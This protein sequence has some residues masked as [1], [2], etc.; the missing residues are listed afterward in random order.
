VSIWNAACATRRITVEIHAQTMSRYRTQ[1]I[2]YAFLTL[3]LCGS[4][5][6]VLADDL[7]LGM[8]ALEMGHT[9]Q[10]I[11]LWRPLAE[12]GNVD[13]Q[14]GLGVIYN[15]AMGVEQDFA[16][17]NYWFLR[18]AEQG[19][20]PAQF[21]LGNAYKNGSGMAVD[22]AMAVIWWRKAAE[23]DFGPAQFNLGSALLEG[24]GTPRDRA[25]GVEWYRRAAAHGHAQAQSYLEAQ[26]GDVT[27]TGKDAARSDTRPSAID[28]PATESEPESGKARPI[29]FPASAA[30]ANET[31]L[32]AD[33]M[34]WLDRDTHTHTVQLMASQAEADVRAY[35]AQHAL[36]DTAICHY[37]VKGKFWYALLY[38]RYD[39]ADSARTALGK[40]SAQ[41]RAGGGYVRRIAEIR[42][43]VNKQ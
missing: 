21:N 38:G 32:P 22:P 11:E 43:A 25:A 1:F 2:V 41:V 14:F 5:P 3:W 39:S 7:A 27:P 31:A 36:H 19:Y 17:A 13:A 26:S 24:L 10:A 12:A 28:A 9:A 23:Q 37:R 34:D 4:T 20:A 33:C 18:A 16:E 35:I 30:T 15:D 8:R 29:P 6:A 40:L 42:T